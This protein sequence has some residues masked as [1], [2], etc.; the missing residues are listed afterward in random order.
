LKEPR[1]AGSARQRERLAGGVEVR[2]AE[3][4]DLPAMLALE[5]HFPGDKLGR[6]SLTRFLSADSAEVWVATEAGAVVGD[7]IVLYRRGFD[8]ARLYSIVVDPRFRGRGIAG[9][10]LEQAE[11]AARIR[12]AV[13]MRLEV[14]SDNRAA[15]GL[16]EARG[17]E[18]VGTTDGYYEDDSSAL[19]M[20]K[21]FAA[22]QAHLL[23]VPYHPQS[24]D[25]TCGPAALMMA[26][27]AVGWTTPFSQA[28][29]VALW[30][31]ATTVFMLSGHGG[32]SA[33]GLAV[34]ARRRGV[35]ARV[36]T[37]DDAVPF[38][39]S[40]RQ[41]EKKTVIALSHRAFVAAL[42]DDPEAVRIG[43][44]SDRDVVAHLQAGAVPIV[45]ISGWRFHAERVPH[46][47]V[48]TGWDDDYLYVHDP[49]VPESSQRADAL[50]LALP[51]RQ[52]AALARY[53]RARHRAMVLLG[54][55]RRRGRRSQATRSPNAASPSTK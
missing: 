32:T 47:V 5:E 2:R 13:A 8:T 45:L 31:E 46:W 44:F 35:R 16:Y 23:P 7:A 29:E 53:G 14:R 30:R 17:Y 1:P 12:G 11:A 49:L 3:R 19:R 22:A 54:P 48:V 55:A 52:F 41:E 42:A 38:L 37:R 21:R 43:E 25:F 10:L 27:R 50:H 24:L 36:W 33:H 26:M 15:I 28:E 18:A 6:S 4:S 9:A 51:R 20:R 34:A 40:V 39:D